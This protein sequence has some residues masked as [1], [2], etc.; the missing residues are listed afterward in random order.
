ADKTAGLYSAYATMAALFHRE[1]TG[2]GQ[3]IEV[4][5]LETVTHL[6]MVENLYGLT[7]DPPLGKPAYSRSINPRRKPYKTKDGYI[8]IVPYN[9]KQ[10]E[11]FFEIGGRPGVLED[12]R[13]KE[14]AVRTEHIGEL[15]AII[16]EIASTKTTE[17]WLDLLDKARIPVM[18]Y[19]K[20]EEV[21]NDPHL[22]SV[23]FFERREH[24]H[25]GDYHAVR[26]PV[27]FSKTP[28]E[29]R[30]EAQPVGADTRAILEEL[31]IDPADIEDIVAG[32]H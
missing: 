17:E 11:I 4:P 13:F 21:M 1:R 25:A 16:E 23:D 12:E 24:P 18:R 19:N 29:I 6:N 26:H 32:D 20:V 22:K 31:G 7:F 8:A 5:M 10:W 28:A 14:Y 2:E 9:D 3:F 15:Y 30:K 27:H